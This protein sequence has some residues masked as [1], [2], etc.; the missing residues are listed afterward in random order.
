[1]PVATMHASTHL[2]CLL[3]LITLTLIYLKV[4]ITMVSTAFYPKKCQFLLP[5]LS[6]VKKVC[7][8]AARSHKPRFR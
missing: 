6:V 8:R 7:L 3:S 2:R 1:M 4:S 5:G